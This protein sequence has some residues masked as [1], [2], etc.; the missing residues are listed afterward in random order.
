MKTGEIIKI[1]RR[2]KNL[3]QKELADKINKSLPTIRKQE[4]GSIK[5]PLESLIKIAD[6]LNVP[7]DFLQH[8]NE[9]DLDKDTIPPLEYITEPFVHGVRAVGFGK[10]VPVGGI[11][12]IIFQK[13]DPWVHRGKDEVLKICE[14]AVK[15][16]YSQGCNI[17]FYY[18]IKEKDVLA[19]INKPSDGLSS[20]L[21]S[22]QFLLEFEKIAWFINTELKTIFDEYE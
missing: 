13:K 5:P 18:N 4:N 17:K 11:V 8:P 22:Q 10:P 15:V 14:T 21:W 12:D 3:T 16:L 1:Y 19:H 7:L 6:V 9:E 2:K 20:I